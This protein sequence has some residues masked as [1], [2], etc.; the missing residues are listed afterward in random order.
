MVSVKS[1]ASIGQPFADESSRQGFTLIE[2]IAATTILAI[3]IYLALTAYAF[4]G[5]AWRKGRLADT[6]S[7]DLYRN[8]I[9]CRSAIES[10]YDYYVTDPVNERN[11]IHYPYFVGDSTS[12]AFVTLSSVFSKGIPAAARIRLV[13]SNAGV[14]NLVYEEMPLL[15]QYIKYEDDVPEYESQIVLFENVNRLTIRYYGI[16]ESRYDAAADDYEFIYRWQDDFYGKERKAVPE[17][18]ELSVYGESGD[19]TVWTFSAKARN[20]YKI[21]FL[22]PKSI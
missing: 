2:V 20:P 8:H 3:I 15:R 4:W 7:L 12:I 1:D 11:K 10:V 21:I 19:D 14:Q 13:K 9:L 22:E 16:F 17:I 5:D 6:R 18:I